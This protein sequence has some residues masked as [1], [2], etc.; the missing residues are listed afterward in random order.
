MKKFYSL[1]KVTCLSCI[2]LVGNYSVAQVSTGGKMCSESKI[3]H[4]T[5]I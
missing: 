5:D 3:N 4:G 1:T 2:L